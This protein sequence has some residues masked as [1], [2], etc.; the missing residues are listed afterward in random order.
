MAIQME[1]SA[2][3]FVPSVEENSKFEID[4]LALIYRK[5]TLEQLQTK[6]EGLQKHEIHHD[7]AV[8]SKDA[9]DSQIKLLEQA[10]KLKKAKEH[11][12]VLL[13]TLGLEQVE[14]TGFEKRI[15][16]VQLLEELEDI[17]SSLEN[18][19]LLN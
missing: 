5:M 16:D 12:G 4:R 14:K 13:N 7:E 11:A 18:R 10:I 19:V 17:I 1:P 15:D 8:E 2:R 3:S 9:L 6:L